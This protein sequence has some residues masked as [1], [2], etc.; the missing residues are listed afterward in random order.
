MPTTTSPNA[1]LIGFLCLGVTATGWAMNW[2]I[3]KILLRDWPPLFARGVAGTAAGIILAGIA[4]AYGEKLRVPRHAIPRLLFA[5]FTNVFAWMGFATVALKM[6]S[7][8]EGAL[9]VYTMP[10]WA[11][12]FAW[13]ILGHR[14][15]LRDAIALVL[16]IAGIVVLMG[17][18][19]FA[20]TPDKMVGIALTLG[21]ATLF[22]LGSVLMRTPLPIPPVALA[23]WQVGLGCFPMIILGLIFEK[24]DIA[25]LTPTG[26]GALIYMTL[27]P[28]GICYLTWFATLRR[29]P[30]STAAMGTL[31]VP[32]MGVI[33]AAVVLGEPLG[34]REVIAMALTLGGVT[35]ALRKPAAA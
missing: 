34:L 14:P 23:A 15:G 1:R 22:A 13:P 35:L 5:S 31:V 25:A 27:G 3:I 26:W 7:I 6:L 10:I 18:H 2:P 21:S 33:G 28:M 11:T 20:L 30:P 29:L 16:G 17:E 12:L 24:P 32:V 9:L 4:I 8:G 19:G